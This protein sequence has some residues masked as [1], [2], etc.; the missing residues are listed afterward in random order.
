MENWPHAC[1]GISEDGGACLHGI[2]VLA[3]IMLVMDACW[4]REAALDRSERL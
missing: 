3:F 1:S 4:W 2:L